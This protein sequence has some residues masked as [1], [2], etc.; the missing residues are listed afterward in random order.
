M[1]ERRRARGFRRGRGMLLTAA[2]VALSLGTAG[3]DLDDILSVDLPGQVLGEN[4]ENP[5]LATI[6]VRSVM[7][8]LECAWANYV[9]AAAHHGDEYMN[10]SGNLWFRNWGQR[11]I[12]ANDERFS[13][14]TCGTP[15]SFYGPL[16]TARFQAEDVYDRLT[17]DT[18]AGVPNLERNLA[19][20]RAYGAYALVGLGEGF[21][22][23]TV[24]E[25]EG[26]PGPLMTP[27]QV[28]EKAEGR[29]TEA[30][31]LAQQ[32]GDNAILNLA[33]I[34]RARVRLNLGDYQGVIADA[35]AVTPGYER[36]VTRS[37][38]STRRYNFVYNYLNSRIQSRHGTISLHFRGLTIDDDGRPT[39]EDGVEDPRVITFPVGNLAGHNGTTPS[40]FHEKN[41]SRSTAMPLATYREVRLMHA[42][43]L[44]QL[45]DVEGA[46]ALINERRVEL[47]LPTFDLPAS[48]G[49][50]IDLILAERSRELFAEGGHR[51][52]DMLRYRGTA[53][54]IPFLGEPGSIHPDGLDTIGAAY[55][56]ATC[57]PLPFVERIGNP[58][59]GG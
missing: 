29:F 59:I 47:G 30:I 2:V 50:M 38:S 33:R 23:M 57:Y 25:R 3:C 10:S 18:F 46:R 1:A 39:I 28:L 58:N 26:E 9:A 24:P 16:H 6:L 5:E 15:Y 7:S 56:D 22:E 32:A 37:D 14:A 8:D 20:I 11:R 43:A 31:T 49:E 4:L 51:L 48:Q 44:A 21:C 54:E 13:S 53:H 40:W 19:T 41:T 35:S 34:G 55:G 17:S 52:N 36:M 12:E 42:E 45:G 27:T